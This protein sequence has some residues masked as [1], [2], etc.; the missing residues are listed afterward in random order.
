M[1]GSTQDGSMAH[2]KTICWAG[3]LAGLL[4]A[5]MAQAADDS[6]PGVVERTGQAIDHAAKKTGEAV[7]PVA[8]KTGA[9]V[10][11]AG[12]KVGDALGTADK[13]IQ[14]VV[15]KDG[16]YQGKPTLPADSVAH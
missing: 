10:K 2:F 5:G 1:F 3:A 6:S 9:A 7:K 11:K 15:N 8:E 16:K 14:H 4:T 12:E 13:K